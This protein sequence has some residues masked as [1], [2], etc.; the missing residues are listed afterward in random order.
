MEMEEANGKREMSLA[1]AAWKETTR[2]SPLEYG[3]FRLLAAG[4]IGNANAVYVTHTC[5]RQAGIEPGPAPFLPPFEPI[6]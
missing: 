6:R 2:D 4:E 1:L 5:Q 3:R